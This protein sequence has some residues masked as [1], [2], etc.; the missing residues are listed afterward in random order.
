M[1][2][3]TLVRGWASY[4]FNDRTVVRTG[5]GISYFARRMAQ[6]NFPI[7][8]ANGFPSVNGFVSSAVTMTTVVP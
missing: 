6:F 5:Y 3:I 4:R 7:L 8:Q 2:I 1:P